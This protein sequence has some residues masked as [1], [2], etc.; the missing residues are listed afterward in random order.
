MK[1]ILAFISLAL[2]LC[3]CA[4]EKKHVLVLTERGG[5]HRDF[6]AAATKWIAEEGERQGFDVVEIHNTDPITREYLAGFDAIIQLDYV[7]YTWTDTQKDAFIDYIEGGKGG[8]VGFHH[9]TLLGD[10]DG[11]HNWEWFSDFMGHIH[12]EN[13]IA[14]LSDGIVNVEATE[15]PVMQGVAQSFVIRDDEW[16]IYDKSPRLDPAIKVL[17]TVDEDSYSADTS[18]KMGDHPVVWTNTEAAARNIYFQFGHSPKLITDNPDFLRMFSNAIAF[19]LG[20]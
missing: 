5:W 12:Y 13:Y 1:K 16:Y 18:I 17:A 15:H 4:Q 20:K 9:A 14:E 8:W 6:T 7:T 11:F 3:S 19:V 10:F 2:L